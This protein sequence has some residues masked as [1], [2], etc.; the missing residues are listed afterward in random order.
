MRN[1]R[2]KKYLLITRSLS[3]VGEVEEYC[4][5]YGI[6]PVLCPL[7][8]I[9]V[10]QVRFEL[11]DGEGIFVFTSKNAVSEEVLERCVGGVIVCTGRECAKKI[12]SLGFEVSLVSNEENEESLAREVIEKFQGKSSWIKLFQ[13]NTGSSYLEDELS[14]KGFLVERLLAYEVLPRAVDEKVFRQFLNK[15]VRD[16]SFYVSLLSV[17]TADR[18]FEEL[19]RCAPEMEQQVKDQIRFLV[20]GGKCEA[21][22]RGM[23]VKNILKPEV[24]SIEA[25]VVLLAPGLRKK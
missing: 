22:L 18:F 19:K 8:E 9:D 14:A 20:L 23:G 12:E 16:S 17:Y 13:G 7:L 2:A 1:E 10:R 24:N 3:Q 6:E 25:G 15:A 4:R 5:E 11:G 21:R